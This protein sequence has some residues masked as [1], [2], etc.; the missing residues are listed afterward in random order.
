M[1]AASL[2]QRPSHRARQPFAKRDPREADRCLYE[3]AL[4][5][6]IAAQASCTG[7]SCLAVQ[8]SLRLVV[9]FFY[10]PHDVL[11]VCHCI[12]YN[13]GLHCWRGLFVSA[14]GTLQGTFFLFTDIPDRNVGWKYPPSRAPEGYGRV[15][16]PRLQGF[17]LSVVHSGWR[18]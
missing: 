1:S 11:I 5:E 4:L 12:G 3:I 10:N 17:H 15:Q 18:G 13:R 2:S 9:H 7:S 6:V 8:P 16:P 14:D